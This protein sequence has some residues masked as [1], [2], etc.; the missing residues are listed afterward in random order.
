MSQ[1]FP[2]A[3]LRTIQ[4][5]SEKICF[6]LEELDTDII[7]VGNVI[8]QWEVAQTYLGLIESNKLFMLFTE[9]KI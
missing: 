7:K 6:L 2:K 9:V 3:I 8:T 4:E 5:Y 1:W